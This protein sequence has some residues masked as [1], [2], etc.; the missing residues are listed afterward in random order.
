LSSPFYTSDEL[1][2]LGCTAVGEG[3][4]VSRLAQFYAFRGAIG[5]RSRIDDFAIIKGNVELGAYVHISSF[6]LLGGTG[7]RLVIEDFG[8]IA[9]YVGVYTDTDDYAT[10][11]LTNA[12]VPKDLRVGIAG[13]VRIGRGALIGAHCV[14]LPNTVVDDYATIGAHCI[15]KGHYE[16]GGVYITAM[17]S[18]RRVG[19]RD[20]GSIQRHEAK[21]LQ[22]R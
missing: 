3:A 9:A 5:A 1:V 16:R 8:G 12:T 14:V 6:C 19:T 18:P 11:R 13:D 22:R 2:A 10:S 21:A 7:G 17:A 15:A 20:I 4:V